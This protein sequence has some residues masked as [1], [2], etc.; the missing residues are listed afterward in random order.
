VIIPIPHKVTEHGTF[1]GRVVDE[2]T[3]DPLPGINV[4]IGDVDGEPVATTDC[5]GRFAISESEGWRPFW[6]VPLL[7]FDFFPFCE[8]IVLDDP[9]LAPAEKGWRRYRQ[10]ALE[11]NS[12]SPGNV[13]GDSGK[14]NRGVED[15]LGSV[16]LKRLDALEL[17][18]STSKT[19]EYGTL[20]GR[21][22]DDETETSIPGAL[23]YLGKAY[24]EPDARTDSEGRFVI[25][26]CEQSRASSD[27][28][29]MIVVDVQGVVPARDGRRRYRGLSLEVR[30]C[31]PERA[32]A[33]AGEIHPG[34]EDDLG[35]IRLKAFNPNPPP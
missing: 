33:H 12:Y 24:G 34:V 15:D 16:S 22:I 5:D 4:Y 7:P 19:V 14:V 2:I 13:V 29:S 8:R 31:P 30:C 6:V 3:S 18:R 21:V 11:V 20:R 23:V 35:T 1:R 27:E 25:A 28:L 9:C 17:I 10:L 26:E 32:A